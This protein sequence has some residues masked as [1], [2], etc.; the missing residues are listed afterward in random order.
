MSELNLLALSAVLLAALLLI[1]LLG[2]AWYSGL[3]C[4]VTVRSG[5]PPIRAFTLA[6]KYK[7]GPYREAGR[8]FTEITSIAPKLSSVGIY[9][10]HPKQ[11]SEDKL[12][13]I[14]GSILSEGDEKPSEELVKLFEKFGFKII[15]FPEVTHV[16]MTSFPFTT[17]L[18]L[19][20]AMYRVYPVLNNYIKE[21]KL[22]A[23]PCLEIY[24]G[25]LIYFMCP[26]ARQ[27]DFYVP[28]LKEADKKQ[29]EEEG[30]DALTDTGGDSF[31][32]NSSVTYEAY[33]ESR[34]TSLA[35]SV[36]PDLTNKEL[37][38]SDKNDKSESVASGSSFEDLDLEANSNGEQPGL[39]QLASEAKAELDQL[40]EA[41]KSLDIRRMEEE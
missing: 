10:D 23:H 13:Y 25:D 7:Q 5:P 38:D 36:T 18:S 2:L 21:R 31:S 24:R 11:E 27:G 20:I 34:E 3:L 4:E 15:S 40:T 29:K 26:L 12:R 14:A 35:K 32:D 41:K 30:D 28:E 22:C 1:S 16:V 6:Y 8:L 19:F 9:Y 37:E 17:F 33:T 39:T